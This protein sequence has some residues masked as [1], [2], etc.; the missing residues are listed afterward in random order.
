MQSINSK[1]IT[2]SFN[3]KS[4]NSILPKSIFISNLK[5]II[6][7]LLICFFVVCMIIKPKLCI[8]S[9]YSGLSV[10][11]KCVL[12]SL[13]PFM[14][15]TKVLSNLNF[16]NKLTDKFYKINQILFNAPKISSY[17]FL[18]SV[19]SGYPVG[20][21]LISEY[22]KMGIINT[23]QANKLCSFC[24]TSGPLFIIGSV[25]TAMFMD[26][27]LGYIMFVCH[28]LASILNGIIFRNAYNENKNNSQIIDSRNDNN[29][30]LKVI[31]EKEN[32]KKITKNNG[33]IIENTQNNQNLLANSMKDSIISVLLVGGWIAIAFLI[34]DVCNDLNLLYPINKLIQLL[35]LNY[36]SA[37]A[38]SSGILEVSKGCLMLS[39]L[40][41]SKTLLCAIASFVIGFGGLSVF[42]QGATFLKE[43]KVNLKF[44][45]LTKIT[46][47]LIA[48]LLTY[49]LCLFLL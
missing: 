5:N 4:T 7:S 25:G 46:H 3:I 31:T 17:I 19:I 33:N 16:I 8:N 29:Y 9:V 21:K 34:I 37:N 38:V 20:A 45:L 42:L 11:A 39:N 23:N 48:S 41:I 15:F 43:A 1:Q 26:A 6:F 40:N 24:S 30:D 36:Q 18:M 22:R 35:G 47:G 28:V 10:W 13:L 2:N 12:P 49:I 44:Y 27:K 32:F 14:F